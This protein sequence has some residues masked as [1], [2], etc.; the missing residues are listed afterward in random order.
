L[1]ADAAAAAVVDRVLAESEG[2]TGPWI[3][4][5]LCAAAVDESLL[6]VAAS[7]P[8]RDVEAF[9]AV[10]EDGPLIIGNR[11]TSGIDGLVSTAWGA[12]IA[13]QDAGGSTAYALLGDLAFIHDSNGLVV[14]SEEPAPDLVIVVVD[15]DGGGIFSGLEQ[16]DERYAE[17][18]ERVFGTPHGTDIAE[19][20]A[21]MGVPG[22]YEV[23]TPEEFDEALATATQEGSVQVIVA[24][25][26]SRADE[27]LVR[28]HLREAI[29]TRT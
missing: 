28:Q 21:S 23:N 5:K 6:L 8:V 22:V 26:V 4:R 2:L 18:F 17:D 25:T 15:N 29:A 19:M 10:R 16:G 14:G 3:A 13:H 1:L 9:A 27:M 11:G 7:R 20:A 12:A 24:H